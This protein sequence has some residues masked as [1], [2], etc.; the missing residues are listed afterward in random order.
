MYTT[1]G[2]VIICVTKT[3]I[4]Y[5]CNVIVI[6]IYIYMYNSVHLEFQI[7]MCYIM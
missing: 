1:G 2:C 6:Y 5:N 3:L 4:Y 7:G